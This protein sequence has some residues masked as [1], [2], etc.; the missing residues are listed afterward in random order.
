MSRK[1]DILSLSH[2]ALNQYVSSTHPSFRANQIYRWLWKQGVRSFDEM[3]NV[4]ESLRNRLKEECTINSLE[5]AQSQTSSD[6]TI[7]LLFA[8]RTGQHMETVLH[9]DQLG[10]DANPRTGF[11][12]R[13][14][15]D[16]VNA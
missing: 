15:K 3:T 12:Y 9:L 1:I 14:F 13:A 10:S 5:L 8:L 16:V 6:G 11:A 7:K 2:S 4:P